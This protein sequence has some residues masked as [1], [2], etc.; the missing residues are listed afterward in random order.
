MIEKLGL[1]AA[2]L[3]YVGTIIGVFAYLR[4]IWRSIKA[5]KNGVLCLLRSNIRK[6]YYA[7]C[8]EPQPTIREY[9]RQDLDDL[10]AGYHTLGGNHFVD[11]LYEKMRHWKVVT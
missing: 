9:E 11:D 8:D 7:H 5:E 1:I 3:G 2:V 6:V 10:Y 4:K